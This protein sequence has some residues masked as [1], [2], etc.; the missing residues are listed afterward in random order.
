M[1]KVEKK[2]FII[3]AIVSVTF[4][5][6]IVGFNAYRLCELH[7]YIEKIQKFALENG[8]ILRHQKDAQCRINKLPIIKSNSDSYISKLVAEKLYTEESCLYRKLENCTLEKTED[9][10]TFSA[11]LAGE[12]YLKGEADDSRYEFNTNGTRKRLFV[13]TDVSEVENAKAVIKSI[14]PGQKDNIKI[15][16]TGENEPDGTKFL[17]ED[18]LYLMQTLEVRKKYTMSMFLLFLFYLSSA[19]SLVFSSRIFIRSVFAV[20][21][22]FIS[23]FMLHI[24]VFAIF[25]ML[26]VFT[27]L[28]WFISFTKNR[29]IIGVY[30]LALS[31]ILDASIMYSGYRITFDSDYIAEFIGFT[32][33]AIDVFACSMLL[34]SIHRSIKDFNLTPVVDLNRRKVRIELA[35]SFLPYITKLNAS[36]SRYIKKNFFTSCYEITINEK[37]N[38]NEYKVIKD[39]KLCSSKKIENEVMTD[40]DIDILLGIVIIAKYN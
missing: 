13:P 15:I 3:V 1:N 16:L 39:G 19:T 17:Q 38:K 6:G 29:F 5:A 24:P 30:Y 21:A 12:Y 34:D 4:M 28:D 27:V 9:T 2:F 40:A 11:K 32:V 20:V 33:S 26:V 22:L 35:A 31:V 23:C 7:Q 14:I 10:I 37:L 8:I 25:L 18:F 36:L